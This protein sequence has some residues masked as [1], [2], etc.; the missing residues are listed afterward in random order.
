MFEE[1]YR[2]MNDQL[3]PGT[4]LV[5]STLRQVRHPP[6]RRG[7]A[8]VAAAALLL[9]AATPLAARTEPGYQLLYAVAPAAAQFFQPVQ[10]SCEDNGIRMEV[11]SVQTEGDTAQAYIALTD[12]TGSR[13]D[14]TTDL[15][16][17]CS[18]H[19]P[20]DSSG[21]CELAAFDPEAGTA[22]FRVTEQTM[23][24]QAVPGGKMTFSMSCFLSGKKSTENLTLD[25]PLTKY[26]Q[27]APTTDGYQCRGGGYSAP[28]GKAMLEDPPM[29]EPGSAIAN[30][31]NGFSIT[32][33]GYV[34]DLLHIQVKI[35]DL[36]KTDGHCFL[37]LEDAEGN[38]VTSLYSAAFTG[39][40]EREDYYE[41]VFD[42]APEE[43][44]PY[45][46]CGDFYTSGRYTEGSWR[47]TFPLN[48][49]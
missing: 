8:A 39:G 2:A 49:S 24:G 17:S 10:E 16:D 37:R 44:G 30:P 12:L 19:V 33:I 4:E 47:V 7:A 3:H 45:S 40:E 38:A 29:L 43:L 36:P 18:M 14:E 11:V 28:N 15:Y 21:H 31:V 22:L 35:E 41:F 27:E 23:S 13:V 34:N 42:L 1:A 32:A 48:R 26:A 6:L 9:C 20:F 5:E 25:I 46:I